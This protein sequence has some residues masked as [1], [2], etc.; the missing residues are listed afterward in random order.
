M[1]ICY[2]GVTTYLAMEFFC[3]EG[4]L[5]QQNGQTNL[6]NAM[7]LMYTTCCLLFHN[8]NSLPLVPIVASIPTYQ[9]DILGL[10]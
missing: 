10:A 5:D 6:D 4:G 1:D 7:L 9:T 3:G 8:P 2:F